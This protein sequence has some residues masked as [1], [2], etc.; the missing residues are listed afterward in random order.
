MQKCKNAK[1]GEHKKLAKSNKNKK[2]DVRKKK[3]KER[4]AQNLRKWGILGIKRYLK[5]KRYFCKKNFRKKLYA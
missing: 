4:D 1:K 5:K 3:L 2:I